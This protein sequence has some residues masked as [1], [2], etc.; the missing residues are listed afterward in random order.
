MS[1]KIC[2]KT[3]IFVDNIISSFET[4]EDALQYYR[5]ANEIMKRAG[6]PLQAWGFSNPIIEKK[7]E[8]DGR[9]DPKPI[10]KTLGLQWDRHADLLN[11]QPINLLSYCSTSA[12]HKDVLRGTH[13]VYDPFGFYGPLSVRGK[14][15]L[16]DLNKE[17]IPFNQE[18]SEQER[19]QWRKIATDISDAIDKR[20]MS[21]PRPFFLDSLKQFE[22]H[23]FGDASKRAYGAVAYLVQNNQVSFVMSKSKIN[24]KKRRRKRA[25]HSG[26]RT[27]GGFHWNPPCG[28]QCFRPGTSQRSPQNFLLE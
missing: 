21:L 16:Q 1:P 13:S 17:N 28:N 4:Q 26:S 14:I 11:I 2:K 9:L 10:S 27:Y 3:N 22:L 25:I 12:T 6:L 19:V 20:I 7:L 18:L 15:L 8:K 23:M 24:P 5:S